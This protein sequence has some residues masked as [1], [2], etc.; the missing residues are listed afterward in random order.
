[1]H[2]ACVRIA[3]VRIAS[4]RPIAIGGPH[5][6]LELEYLAAVAVWVCHGYGRVCQTDAVDADVVVAGAE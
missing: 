1:M 6:Q 2:L 3:V 5:V 4:L